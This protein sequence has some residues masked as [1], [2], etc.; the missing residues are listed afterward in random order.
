MTIAC[1]LAEIRQKRT[2]TLAE[3]AEGSGVS[4]SSLSRIEHGQVLPHLEAV[5]RLTGWLNLQPVDL[6]PDYDELRRDRH[7]FR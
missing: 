6:W 2:L 7:G 4:V 5:R 3:L 1:K